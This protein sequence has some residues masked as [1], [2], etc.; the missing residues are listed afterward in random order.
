MTLRFVR[1]GPSLW[2][3]R[4]L[5][6]APSTGR[7]REPPLPLRME[8][9]YHLT[10]ASL[11][12]LLLS[13]STAARADKPPPAPAPPKS[14]P[15]AQM[16]AVLDQLVVLGPKPIET[17]SPADARRQPTAGDAVIQL[18][19]ARGN[20]APDKLPPVGS[21]ETVSIPDAEGKPMS[22]RVYTPP[23]TG[24]FPIVVYLHGGGWVLG[25]LDTYDASC[26]AI[27]ALAKAIV[28]SVDYRKAPEHPFPA[29]PED[30][31]AA[32]QYVVDHAAQFNGDPKRV[33]IAGES[34]GGN[35]ATVV[36]LMA[37]DR[38]GHMPVHQALIYPVTNYAFDTKSYVDNAQAKPLNA[39]MMQWFF[40]KYLKSP[41]DG[42]NVYVSP[43]RATEA[44]LRG[45][46]PATVV[47][48]EIDPLRDEGAAYAAK[49]T[50]AGVAV[51][52]KDW[53]G[54]AHEFFG[55]GLVVDKA[56]EA[57]VFVAQALDAT[58]GI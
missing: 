17:L 29:A 38:K 12:A 31:Y 49:L 2:V 10:R 57:E 43:L 11:L 5:S 51:K 9:M 25:T 13:L 33:A 22:L 6:G 27:A 15:D 36:C 44:Q 21:V 55:M 58:F 34:A 23:G 3:R 19:Q 41:T 46:P 14:M 32:F 37:K 4:L 16:R 26:R 52:S 24:P 18:L 30:S 39:P 50:R 28:I 53:T 42:A 54:V 47:T 7:R 1:R 40:Q 8:P 20:A 35:L 45:L 56:K 48:D